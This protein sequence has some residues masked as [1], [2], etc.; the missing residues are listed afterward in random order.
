MSRKRTVFVHRWNKHEWY[1]FPT[2]KIGRSGFHPV[3][4]SFTFHFLGWMVFYTRYEEWTAEDLKNHLE[5]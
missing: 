2:I 1:I 4:L 5:K 3:R